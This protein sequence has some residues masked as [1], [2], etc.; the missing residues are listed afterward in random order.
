VALL[1]TLIL[2]GPAFHVLAAALGRPVGYR[3]TVALSLAAAARASLV[4]ACGVAAAVST[5]LR[6]VLGVAKAR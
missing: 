5:S 1:A 3:T 6:A 2:C 4:F